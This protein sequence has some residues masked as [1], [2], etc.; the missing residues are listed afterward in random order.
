MDKVAMENFALEAESHLLQFKAQLLSLD[1]PVLVGGG[2][3]AALAAVVV[4]TLL[5]GFYNLFLHPLHDI[6]GPWIAGATR[7]WLFQRELVK[8]DAHATILKLH[9]KYGPLV[10]ISPDEVS[11]ND[12]T[13][14]TEIYSQTSKF[15]KAKYFYYAFTDQTANLFSMYD[16]KEHIQ[17]KRLMSAAFSK[18]AILQREDKIYTMA[19]QL[20]DRIAGI[21]D[22]KQQFPLLSS[23]HCMTLDLISEFVF[24]EAP[25]SLSLSDFK[26]PIV[27]EIANASATIAFFQQFPTCRELLRLAGHYKIKAIPNPFLGLGQ[28]ADKG[29]EIMRSPDNTKWTLFGAMVETAKK[30]GITLSNEHLVSEGILMLVAGTDTTA[31]ALSTTTHNLI[32]R[33]ELFEKLRQEI[34]TV[35][36][37]LDSRPKYSDLDALPFLD[38]CVK[39]GLRI[40]SPVRGRLPRVVPKEGWTFKGRFFKPGTIVSAS[41]LYLLHDED[42]F[43]S[44]E[45]FDPNRWLGLEDQR[46]EKLKYFHPFSRGTRQCIGQNLSLIEQKITLSRLVLRFSPVAVSKPSIE[47]GELGT[48]AVP[49]TPLYAQL[50]CN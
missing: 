21:S 38:A 4:I 15:P 25:G 26:S 12:V 48:N 33:P 30:H 29:L 39:E 17:D 34:M 24:G 19:D 44:P 35:A 10:R 16:K 41:S 3:L 23:F 14:Y 20:M 7:W 42:A 18:A 40:S 49:D 2:V 32:R 9:Q 5:K 31:I 11:V 46:A 36:P 27:Q 47:W 13:A 1:R 22:A 28:V 37:T 43:P 6:P 45:T 50:K 8:E